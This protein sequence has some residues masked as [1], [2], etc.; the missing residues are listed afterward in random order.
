[1]V[2]ATRRYVH[3]ITQHLDN[4]GLMIFMFFI[5]LSKCVVRL[6][7]A[8]RCIS[9][10]KKLKTRAKLARLA[11]SFKCGRILI[12]LHS[13]IQILAALRFTSLVNMQVPSQTQTVEQWLCCCLRR[14]ES[15]QRCNNQRFRAVS[16]RF[17]PTCSRSPRLLRRVPPV[18]QHARVPVRRTLQETQTVAGCGGL[19]T[20]P[21]GLAKIFSA[22]TTAR[23]TSRVV[24]CS[25]AIVKHRE[26]ECAPPA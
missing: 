25:T 7:F 17:S 1:M 12:A 16:H 26:L 23:C 24:R 4:R 8:S 10:A 22:F 5:A 11:Y 13:T 2:F 20:L 6:E 3:S 18:A 19:R 9:Q 21:S 14:R 15:L